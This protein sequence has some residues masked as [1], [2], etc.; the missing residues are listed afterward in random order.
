MWRNFFWS[1]SVSGYF[2]ATKKRTIFLRLPLQC[3]G[4]EVSGRIPLC[5]YT[6]I[7]LEK[8]TVRKRSIFR[9][10]VQINI[11]NIGIPENTLILFIPVS[12]V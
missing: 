5:R 12:I 2:R 9:Y 8:D 10:T 4:T 11:R 7:P 3:A 6:N 1:K